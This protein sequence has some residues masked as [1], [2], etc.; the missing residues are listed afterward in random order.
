MREYILPY[1]PKQ[2]FGIDIGFGNDKIRD[3]FVGADQ[4]HPYS[5]GH[6]YRVDLVC[7]V[8]QCVPVADNSFDVVYSSHL[9]EDFV[10]TV[11]ILKEFTRIGKDGGRMILVFPDQKKYKEECRRKN[12]L[13][14]GSHKIANMGI[15]YMTQKIIEAGELEIIANFEVPTYNCVVVCDIHKNKKED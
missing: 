4:K 9:I 5:G 1:I 12:E 6:G 3:D 2:C 11:K 15:A 10:D 13:S 8:N 14:N 7:D